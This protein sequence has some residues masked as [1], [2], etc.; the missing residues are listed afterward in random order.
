M[1]KIK[2]NNDKLMIGQIVYH[3]RNCYRGVIVDVD[4]VFSWT[5]RWYVAMAKSKPPKNMPWY[6]ILV[7]G[8][9]HMTYVAERNLDNDI[10]S[11]PVDHPLLDLFFNEKAKRLYYNS[12][13]TLN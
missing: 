6:H 7:D 13:S 2:I 12:A 10:T 9:D 4:P 1:K 8:E 3:K 5:S 11:D